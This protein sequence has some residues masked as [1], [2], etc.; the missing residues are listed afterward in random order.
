M[1]TLSSPSS[2]VVSFCDYRF[3]IYSAS[4]HTVNQIISIE[5]CK[6][7]IEEGN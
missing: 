2:G 6:T 5:N 4:E 7:H 3:S 1:P